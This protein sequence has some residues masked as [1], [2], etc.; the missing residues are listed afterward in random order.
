[1]LF[2]ILIIIE[3][4]INNKLSYVFSIQDRTVEFTIEGKYNGS[5]RMGQ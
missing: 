1:M 2:D 5:Y 3:M 4:K